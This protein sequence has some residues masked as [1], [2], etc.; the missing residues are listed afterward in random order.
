MMLELPR[1]TERFGSVRIND[2][3]RVLLLESAEDG[4]VAQTG[5]FN[6]PPS[7]IEEIMRK[8][9]IVVPIKDEKLRV[10]EGVISAIPSECLVIIV[11]NSKREGIDRFKMEQDMV[12]QHQHYTNRDIWMI[13]QKDHGLGTALKQVGYEDLSD[14]QGRVRNG[15]GEGMIL[16]MLMAKAAAKDYV[17]FVDS[18]NYVPGA[19]HEYVT[20]YAATFH[21]LRTPYAMVRISWASKPKIMEGSIYFSK[22]G[23]VST[24]TNKY[25]N[26]II[27]GFTGFETEVVRSGNSG[28]HAMT[29]KLAEILDYGSGFAIE[30]YEIL[31]IL[32]QFGGILEPKYTDPIEKGVEIFQVET[33]NPHFHEEKGEE[34]LN[35]MI[36]NALSS[37]V[38][39]PLCSEGIR[40]EIEN[41]FPGGQPYAKENMRG[42]RGFGRVDTKAFLEYL[43]QNNALYTFSK[44]LQ[45]T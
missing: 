16:G 24:A 40:K 44:R 6:A 30:P 15:K 42:L 25:L 45:P 18:D 34:H 8:M 4:N 41:E 5:V 3:Q 20:A 28:D 35:E 19:V 9:A 23:R 31:N 2:L 37:I 11:S 21:L 36:S 14:D 39:S 29:M 32:E 33:R 17:G 38:S 13:H 10:V 26:K 1:R 7:K 27:S 22:W 43:L 12:E